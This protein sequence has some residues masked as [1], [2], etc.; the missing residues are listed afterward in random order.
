MDMARVFVRMTINGGDAD[1][2]VLVPEN[3]VVRNKYKDDALTHVG[4]EEVRAAISKAL[5]EQRMGDAHFV[6]D[7]WSVFPL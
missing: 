2:V 4:Y 3:M 1:S 6:L 7:R 5:R